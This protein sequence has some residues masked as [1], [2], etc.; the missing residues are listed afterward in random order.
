MTMSIKI[1]EYMNNMPETLNTKKEI[2]E[3]FKNAMKKI[4]EK[5]KDQE[6]KPKKELNG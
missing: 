2:D 1:K 3:Y 4:L 6:D 5:N